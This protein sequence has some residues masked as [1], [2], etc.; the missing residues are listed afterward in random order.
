VSKQFA[1]YR[2]KTI[3]EL[4]EI[5]ER[6]ERERDEAEH[7]A[8][9]FRRQVAAHQE[10]IAIKERERNDA[11]HLAECRDR[12]LTD[13]E[14][15]LEEARKVTLEVGFK[16]KAHLRDNCDGWTTTELGDALRIIDRQP[17]LN[18]NGESS[19]VRPAGTDHDTGADGGEANG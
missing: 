11:L 14:E 10:I 2:Q 8:E 5:C 9:M 18:E 19:G 17:W 6:L 3:I 7:N 13:C 15:Q 16:I 1:N 12:E 4:S